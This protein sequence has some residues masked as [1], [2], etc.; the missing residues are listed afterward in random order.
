MR[1]MTLY[2]RFIGDY[3]VYRG[4]PLIE[5]AFAVAEKA[6]EGQLRNSGEPYIV[7]PYEVTRILA[8]LGLDNVS[9]CA[10]M[11]HDV[12][13]DTEFTIENVEM[14]FSAEIARIVDGVTKLKK[15]DFQSKED[16]QA[17]S[18]R[19][20]FLAMASD[21]RVILIKLADR[22]HNMRTLGYK[23]PEKQ[24]EKAKETLEIYAPLADRLGISTFKWEFEDLA[25]KYLEPEAYFD[26]AHKLNSTRQEREEYIE[27][28]V[29]VLR[30]KVAALGIP[31]EIEGRPKHI[32]SIYK[33]MKN[34]AKTF[35]ELY[36]IIAVRVIVPSVKDCYAVLGTVHTVWRPLPMRFKDYIAVP[37][38]NMYQSL[39]TTLVGIDGKP[40][41]VQIRTEE[42]HRTAEYGIAAHWK[43]KE[44]ISGQ[45]TGLDAKLSWL[46]ELMEWQNDMR[47]PKEFMEA[48]KINFFS[49]TVFVFTPKGDVKDLTKGSTPLDFAYGVH[50]Q[51]G[52]R[53]VGAKV[54]GR[55]VPLNYELKTGDIVEV[56]TNPQSKGPS[57]D[58]IDMVKTAQARSK[59]RA[60]FKKEQREENEEKG[61]EILEKEAKRK[62]YELS[63]L[64]QSE[65]LK[66][67]YKRFSVNSLGDMMAAVGYGG[68]TPNQI[69]LRLIE[70]YK[71]ENKIEEDF[72]EQKQVAKKFRPSKNATVTVKGYSDMVVHL[73]KCCNPLPGDDIIGYI[74][75]GR[76]VSVHRTDCSNIN[77]TDFPPD[78]RI[79]VSWAAD[80]TGR[81][82]VEVQVE[83]D[84]RAGIFMDI[85]QMLY[86]LGYSFLNIN[87]KRNEKNKTFAI[88]FR[89]EVS[90]IADLEALMDKIRTIPSVTSVFRV[91]K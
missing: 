13:E 67:L 48:L 74:T 91:N 4:D 23:T 68:L 69:L 21:I 3:P 1:R 27:N 46:R 31:A 47:D 79:E 43:Y 66:P 50:S 58:W 89:I 9:I 88:S 7:H 41:E 30:E 65:W 72:L 44:G 39:H 63:D 78:R 62:G 40:F 80:E 81:Y 6:H 49:D 76:G 57:R 59:I 32:Y 83:G 84:D 34:K 61:R 37:K 55:I 8:D 51:I 17:E 11:L 20:M 70:A 90:A 71:K 25:L 15:F 5:K 53:C 56:L 22:L 18:M 26:V 10:S 2:Q 16:A 33:K 85:S 82:D 64:L 29:G 87:A 19:K 86:S 14:A 60:W 77:D 28:I 54:N 36:D 24:R 38:A 35:E 12:P 42:M 73:A 75:R 52:N 45:T